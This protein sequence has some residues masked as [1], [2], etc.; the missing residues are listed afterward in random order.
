MWNGTLDFLVWNGEESCV[1]AY[2]PYPQ[3]SD[4]F[5]FFLPPHPLYNISA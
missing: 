3:Y 5:I 1:D 2:L 4:I